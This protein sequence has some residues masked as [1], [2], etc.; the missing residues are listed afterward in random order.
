MSD[1]LEVES[2]DLEG[3][4]V[5]HQADGKVVFID[6]ALPGELV[7]AQITRQKPSYNRAKLIEVVRPSAQRVEPPCPNF[8]VCGGCLMQHLEPTA[9]VAIK[10][11][12]LEDAFNHIG[13]V[14]PKQLLAAM[15]GPYFGYRFRARFSARFVQKK[16]GMLVGFR[17][18]NG[19]YV[20]DMDQCLVIPKHVSK[21]LRP[22]RT[23]LSTLSRPDRI[24]QIELAV[25]DDCTVLTLRHMEPLT[26]SDLHTLREFAKQHHIVWWLQPKGPE[27]AHPLDP[28]D[29]ECL[30]YELPDYGLKM[31]F[32]PAD[33][34]QVN[35][36]INRELIRRAL[37]LLA[38][39]PQDRVADLFCGL[40]NF[41]LPMARFAKEVVGIEGS[42]TLTQRATEAAA[43]HDMS[44]QAKFSTLNLFE[45]DAHWLRA[46]GYFDR[47]LIDPPRDGA[48]A[49][50]K[51]Y[52]ELSLAERPKRIVY[53]SCNPAT[54]ARDA[55]ILVHHGG[56]D[57]KAAGVI[58]MFPH[59]GHI[60]SIAVFEAGQTGPLKPFQDDSTQ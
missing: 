6:E 20:V 28:E 54:L 60:E 9:Q 37:R 56:Y 59:T 4:G 8:G 19:R 50:A 45:V 5:A 57:L 18:R 33:F 47:V 14:R 10:Q 29:A 25:G 30:Y 39:E 3:R 23:S 42:S 12:A 43:L 51:A 52:S 55:G 26:E 13:K 53:V 15:H 36:Q 11:R 27:T 21:L 41:S 49:V 34:T 32:K 1:L 24:P 7:R 46:L 48:F 2:L 17:E 16:G 31:P 44:E 58:N 38:I 40:G 22:L 35:H